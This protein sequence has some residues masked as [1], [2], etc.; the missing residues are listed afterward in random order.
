MAKTKARQLKCRRCRRPLPQVAR[1]H[2]DPYCSTVCCKAAY[3]VV[4]KV[5]RLHLI[6]GVPLQRQTTAA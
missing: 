4:D 6:N 5:P 1:Q 3:H 2:G